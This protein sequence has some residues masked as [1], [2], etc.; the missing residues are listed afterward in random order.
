MLN[1]NKIASGSSGNA[2]LVTDGH[3]QLLF[4]AGIAYS[5]LAK[6]VEFSKVAGTLITHEHGDHVKAVPELLRRG[7][8]VYMSEGTRRAKNYPLHEVNI[9]KALE[10]VEIGSFL[11][12]PFDVVH[13]VAEPLGFMFESTKTGAK[14]V[15]VVDTSEVLYSFTGVTHWII[16]CNYAQDILDKSEI[17]PAQKFRIT[18]SHFSFEKLVEFFS[19]ADLSRT[20]SITLIHLSDRN[21]DEQAFM[22]GLERV[23]GVPVYV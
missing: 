8:K 3:S 5:K 13:D 6:S 4:D 9:V 11:I 20:Q 7:R 23:T 22:E 2:I 14:G 1:I 10:Q 12:T 16:E 17:H 19:T 18:Q 15:Y 21:S